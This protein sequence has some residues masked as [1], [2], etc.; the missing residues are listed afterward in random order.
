MEASSQI[1][2]SMS[3]CYLLITTFFMNIRS[4]ES[5]MIF[6]MAEL[7]KMPTFDFNNLKLKKIAVSLRLQL[8][9]VS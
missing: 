5:Q 7:K 2:C 9:K 8:E 6:L 1:S 3:K 4:Q